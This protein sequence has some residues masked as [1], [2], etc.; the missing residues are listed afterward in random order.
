MPNIHFVT[1]YDSYAQKDVIKATKKRTEADSIA[2]GLT[3]PRVNSLWYDN[4]ADLIE[5]FN[6]IVS[7]VVEA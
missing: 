2:N 1:G 4:E 6:S 5:V 7:K 3:N